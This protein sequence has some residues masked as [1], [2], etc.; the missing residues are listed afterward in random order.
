MFIN[1]AKSLLE[2][3]LDLH[4]YNAVPSLAKSTGFER[5]LRKQDGNVIHV[6]THLACNI[7]CVLVVIMKSSWV[8]QDKKYHSLQ[9]KTN[10][11]FRSRLILEEG[12]IQK[13]LIEIRLK[14]HVNFKLSLYL[15]AKT[16]F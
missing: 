1:T 10:Q 5:S 16:L 9:N 13:T 6:T 15:L 4:F 12:G 7:L 2:H 3:L 8:T 14:I 11:K